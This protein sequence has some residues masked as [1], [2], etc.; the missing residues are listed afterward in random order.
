MENVPDLPKLPDPAEMETVLPNIFSPE[1]IW[2]DPE[3]V[4]KFVT[5]QGFV[6][7][8][9]GL[10]STTSIVKDLEEL[11]KLVRPPMT[12][13]TRFYWTQEQRDK[14]DNS[15]TFEKVFSWFKERLRQEGS[16][17]WKW[18]AVLTT[19]SRPL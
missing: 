11:K 5:Q 7:V 12:L 3:A 15:E 19:A 14:L 10:V 4:R 2:H 6:N 9:S 13:L 16:I 18:T 8:E 1:K 17:S